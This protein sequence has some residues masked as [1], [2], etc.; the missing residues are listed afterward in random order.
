MLAKEN[1]SE[2]HIMELRSI[3]HRDPALLE[4]AVYAF[5]L[6]EALT[7]VGM[8][9]IF[10]G[11]TALLL[12]L[13]KPMRLST[14]IDIVVKPGTEVDGFIRQVAKIFPF[15]D[16]DEQKRI[17]RNDIV[18][19]HFKFTYKSPIT[20]SDIYI[21]LDI[22]FEE[23]KYS[24]L[25]SRQ[26]K[27]DLLLTEGECLSVSIPSINSILGD[28]LTA[29]APNTIGIPIR[30]YK[31]MEI[32]KQMYDIATLI[33]SFDDIGEVYATYLSVAEAEI[34][35]RG[36]DITPD[37]ALYDTLTASASIAS[38]GIIAPDDYKSYLKGIHDVQGHIFGENFSAEIARTMTPKIMYLCACLINKVPFDKAVDAEWYAK[39]KF[40]NSRLSSLKA[41]KKRDNTAYAFAIMTDRLIGTNFLYQ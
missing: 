41:L 23:N 2:Q 37:N 19:R 4:R 5:G 14:D 38:R 18:K 30:S 24:G 10:K 27:N 40:S 36:L 8:P 21:L 6:L 3:T 28:K 20:G 25:V 22:L 35:Y 31:D 9:F 39:E 32:I 29:F 16:C 34:G 7:R 13:D 15:T 11:G 33:D 17:G 1:F 12:L 26:I